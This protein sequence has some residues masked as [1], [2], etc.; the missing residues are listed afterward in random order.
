MQ[1]RG[2]MPALFVLLLAGAA[3]ASVLT[4]PRTPLSRGLDD[5][6]HVTLYQNG[7]AAIRLVRP[8]EGVGGDQVLTLQLPTTTVFDSLTIRGEGV[9]VKEMRS[10]LAADPALRPGDI[11]T[12]H[13]RDGK[14]TEGTFQS[15]QGGQILLTRDGGTVLVQADQVTRIDV[16]GR[17]VDPSGPGST[18]VDVLVRASAGPRSVHVSYLAQGAGWTPNYV[19]DP[20]TGA[21]TFF[22]TLTGLQDWRNVTLDLMAGSPNVVLTPQPSGDF[23]YGGIGGAV[24]PAAEYDS[25]FGSSQSLGA[26]HRYS[27]RG[28]VD[29]ARG[30][31]IRLAV[32]D[33]KAEIPRHYYHASAGP[34]P[35]EWTGLPELYQ[36]RN[37]LGETLPRGAVRVYLDGEFVGSDTLPALGKTEQGNIT[38]AR[39]NDV[40]ARVVLEREER[41]VPRAE[42]QPNGVLR[43]VVTVTRVYDLQVRNL[44]DETVDTRATFQANEGPRTKVASVQ[45]SPDSTVGGLRVWNAQLP[46]GATSHYRLTIETVEDTF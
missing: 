6:D 40:K 20:A 8:F 33:G 10:S 28:T 17:A 9:A 7:L 31:T 30:Q 15:Q 18:T 12:V 29:M 45:P 36:L 26:L 16:S 13:T 19:L 42:P 44:A 11:L 27:Y 3:F 32:V 14:S 34:S 22:A 38:V 43:N 23:R 2:V 25:G 24:A 5:A 39:S 1:S 35:Y 4:V 41:S 46:A 37:T 21:M